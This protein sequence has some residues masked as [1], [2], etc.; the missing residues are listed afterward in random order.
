MDSNVTRFYSAGSAQ[1]KLDLE[2][3][4]LSYCIKF[5]NGKISSFMLSDT[6]Y[7]ITVTSITKLEDIKKENITT[8]IT[9]M[10]CN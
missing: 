5:T 7:S 3:N 2:N 8:A 4:N 10:T 1:E 6:R 9:N